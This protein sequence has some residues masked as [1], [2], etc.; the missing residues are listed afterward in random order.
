MK[1]TKNKEKKHT[2][3]CPQTCGTNSQN[4]LYVFAA[5][6]CDKLW[7]NITIICLA[8]SKLEHYLCFAD[9]YKSSFFFFLFL[10][11]FMLSI[12]NSSKF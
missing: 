3:N 2:K 7:P 11:A 5:T 9:K 12:S 6:F 1:R 4:P 8:V 10:V